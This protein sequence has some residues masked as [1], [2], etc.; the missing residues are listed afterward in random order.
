MSF[1]SILV[2]LIS[3]M[4]T[5]Y[6]KYRPQRLS[7]IQGQ[8][9]II[10]TLTKQLEKKN[11][12]HAYLFS[13]PK[14]TGKTSTARI[15]AKAL[16]CLSNAKTVEPC[17][18]C[19][20]CLAISSGTH[21]DL[22]EID[23]ASNR[24]IDDIRELREGVKLSASS[25][26]YK[27]YIIDEA[28]M[29][30]PEAFNALLKT[31]EEPPEHVIFILATTEPHKLPG[32]IIS[33]SQ[34]FD[35]GRP[36]ISE[37]TKRLK[38]IV[39]AERWKMEDDGLVEISKA[40]DGAF[41]DAEVLLEKV[42][43]VKPQAKKKDVLAII[44]N[45]TTSQVL[46]LLEIVESKE[47]KKAFLW[48]DDF[49]SGGG[50]I[51]VLNEVIIDSLRKILLIKA[52]AGEDLVKKVAPEE[53]DSLKD[54]ADRLDSDRLNVLIKLFTRSI[55]ELAMAS[56]PQLPLELA[57]VEACD[58]HVG[59]SGE[60]VIPEVIEEAQEDTIPEPE[61]EKVIP[62]VRTQKPKVSLDEEKTLKKVKKDWPKILKEIRKENKALEVFLRAAEP[63]KV[64]ED[65]LFLK[66]YYRF[67]KER[68]EDQKNRK[69]IESVL[70][71]E[72]AQ[73]VRMKGILGERPS[74]KKKSVPKPDGI[75]KEVP[76]AATIF[77]QID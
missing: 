35:F 41:R 36:D 40:G 42:G 10:E 24:G 17:N 67:H 25:G 39:K 23:A 9:K 26:K 72:L 55:E 18:K 7:E 54:T 37:I 29:L 51:R 53:Y 61:V 56:I 30:T 76:D 68:V 34:R 19:K 73:P 58:F 65:T 66:F 59:G 14:G 43:S 46:E 20:S 31:L 74:H 33:R 44:G 28:H 2:K 15:V 57:V 32:T 62:K 8:E 3:P 38:K 27:V 16:N 69:I 6:R 70:E 63:E 47:T 48:L 75:K 4:T 11:I 60:I 52:G 1:L 13:G 49:I 5:L 71:K 50:N 12:H 21:L 45:K 64:E 22:I 77:G